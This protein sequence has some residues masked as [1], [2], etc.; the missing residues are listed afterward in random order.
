[1]KTGKKIL[2]LALVAL[3]LT[4]AM[5]FTAFAATINVDDAF[6]GET[7]SAYKI[8]E[9]T[10]NTSVNPPA[11]SYYLADADYQGALGTALKAVGFKF[12]QSAD[13]TQWFV[14]N[15]DQLTNGAAIAAALS[16]SIDDWKDAALASATTTGTA[17]KKAEFTDLPTGY[18]FVTSSLGSL[19]TLQSHDAEKLVVEKNTTITDTKEVSDNEVQVGDTVT[20]TVTLTDG[21]GTNLEGKV[22]DTMSKGL[23]YNDDAVCVANGKTLVKGTD[24]TVTKTTEADGKTTVVYVFTADVMTELQEGEKIAITYT[25]TVNAD[26]SLDGTEQNIEFSQYS[27]QETNKKTIEVVLEKLKIN[28]TDGS[29]ALK[30]AQF[31]LY[32]TDATCDPPAAD[33][34]PVPVRVLSNAELTAAGIIKEADTIYYEVDKDGTNFTIDMTDASSAVVYSL[35]KDSTYYLRETKAPDGYNLLEKEIEVHLNETNSINVV[36]NSGSI[37]PSTGGIGTTIFYIVGGA[38]VLGAVVV[39]IARRRVRNNKK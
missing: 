5:N 21:K 19:C 27:E 16:A 8:L 17:D 10:S 37:L 30:G 9:Y 25:A 11:Y 38:L 26:A 15:S 32:R 39:L 23:T 13:G 2:A 14:N 12:T 18:W 6:E 33:H 20:Y 4:V 1:M 29:K 7:Y 34:T 36:N 3:M 28:K 35:D 31:E 24:Y 22:I